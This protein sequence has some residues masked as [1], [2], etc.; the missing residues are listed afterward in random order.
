MKRFMTMPH[1]KNPTF[2]H[3]P[4]AFQAETQAWPSSKKASK[5]W[6]IWQAPGPHKSLLSRCPV[7]YRMILQFGNWLF[8]LLRVSIF[9]LLRVSIGSNSWILP[10]IA[11]CQFANASMARQ[12]PATLL[13]DSY[14]MPTEFLSAQSSK[15]KE[16]QMFGGAWIKRLLTDH[17][18]GEAK[19]H[20]NTTW[21][22]DCGAPLNLAKMSS[23]CSSLWFIFPRQT[24]SSKYLKTPNTI[25]SCLKIAVSR[26]LMVDHRLPLQKLHLMVDHGLP[27]LR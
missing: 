19:K 7:G 15:A 12:I 24:E 1:Y 6:L 20:E 16:C 25:W 4:S 18:K 11:W 23:N 5:P 3:G 14:H 8:T 17:A 13:S 10:L 9:T 2:D 22:T 26:N 21:I 27:F